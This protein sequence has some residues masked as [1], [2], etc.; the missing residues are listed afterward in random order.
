MKNLESHRNLMV[1]GSGKRARQENEGT[2]REDEK[3]LAEINLRIAR[4]ENVDLEKEVG[5]IRKRR[6]LIQKDEELINRA[7]M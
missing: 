4:G 1:E 2:L 5:E 7:D 6:G 3:K